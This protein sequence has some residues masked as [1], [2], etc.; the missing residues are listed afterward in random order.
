MC[1][2]VVN[3]F[4]KIAIRSITFITK[5]NFKECATSVNQ[6]AFVKRVFT[7]AIE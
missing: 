5:A 2:F 7:K 3:Y 1:F 6:K 4:D